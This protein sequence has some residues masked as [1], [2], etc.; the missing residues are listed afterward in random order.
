MRTASTGLLWMLAAGVLL[1]ACNVFDPSLYMDAGSDGGAVDASPDAPDAGGECDDRRVPPPRPTVDDGTSGDDVVVVLRDIQFNQLGGAWREIGFDLDGYCTT[2]EAPQSECTPPRAIDDGVGGIDNSFASNLFQSVNLAFGGQLE[3]TARSFQSLGVGALAVI[4]REWNGMAEDPRVDVVVAQTVFGTTA[5]A[6]ADPDFQPG[7]VEPI[8]GDDGTPRLL[9]DMGNEV[10]PPAWDGTDVFY[11]RTD[12]FVD[13]DLDQPIVRD[14]QAY[15]TGGRL[16]VQIPDRITLAFSGGDQGVLIR[17]R[18]A[19]AE[20]SLPLG[21]GDEALP[22]TIGGRWSVD[23]IIRSASAIG[24]CEGTPTY[25]IAIDTIRNAA[26]V[27]S[28]PGGDTSQPCDAVSFG[29]RLSGTPADIGGVVEPPPLPDRCAA[30]S[31]GGGGTGGMG[32]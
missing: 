3:Q 25:D 5:A 6:V 12:A 10:P 22:A 1:G 9:D 29:F 13:G 19:V 24:I 21:G 32:G 2:T 26:D 16:Y 11:L 7:Q 20:L 14:E 17:V 18:G 8:V 27:L 4:V 30:M 23:D 15:V 31:G 28:R